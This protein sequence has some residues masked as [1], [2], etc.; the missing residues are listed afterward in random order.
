VRAGELNQLFTC[1]AEALLGT[2]CLELLN[3]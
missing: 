3:Q 2:A 1:V